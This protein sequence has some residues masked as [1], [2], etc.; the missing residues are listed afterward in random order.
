MDKTVNISKNNIY[1]LKCINNSMCLEAEQME[2][3]VMVLII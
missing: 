1:S 2:S 3:I